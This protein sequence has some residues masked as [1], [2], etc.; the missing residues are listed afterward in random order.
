MTELITKREESTSKRLDDVKQ[1]IS[2]AVSEI[3]EEFEDHLESINENTAEIQSNY[4]FSCELDNKITKLNEKIDEI[5]SILSRLTGKKITKT[6]KYE[7]IDPLTTMEKNVFLN[8]Y[9]EQQPITY[10]ELAKKINMPISLTR[11]YIT[12]LLEKGIPIQKRYIKTRPYIYLDQKFKNLQAKK[13]ILKIEQ[14]I[15]A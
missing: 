11:Q 2:I 13:N 3:H 9:T 7:D 10:A 4:E 5:Y 8:I 14:K 6:A 12:N 15:L 1:K